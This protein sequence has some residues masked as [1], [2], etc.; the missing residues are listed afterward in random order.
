MDDIVATVRETL[1]ADGYTVNSAGVNRGQVRVSLLEADASAA[2][3]RELVTDAVGESAVVGLSVANEAP[4]GEDDVR[5]VIT[6]R[7]RDA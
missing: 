4:E 3:L 5:T 6:F 2:A 1:E 7:Y